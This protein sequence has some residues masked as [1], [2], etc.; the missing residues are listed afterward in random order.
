MGL[1]TALRSRSLVTW[2]L[3]CVAMVAVV[4][5]VLVVAPWLLT[6]YPHHGLTADQVLKAK[7]DVR[8]TLT[9]ALAGIAVAGGLAVTYRSYRLSKSEQ[10]TET[11]TRAIE[12]LGHTDAPVRLGALY[13]LER[14]GQDNPDRRRTVVDV[15]CA[16]LRMP[17]PASADPNNESADATA[18]LRSGERQRPEQELQVRKTA[19]RL[20][21]AHVQRP[22]NTRPEDAAQMRP[23]TQI[24]F[25]PNI[26]LDLVGATLIEFKLHDA[27][28]EVDFRQATFIGTASFAGATFARGALFDGATFK[29]DASFTGAT[30]KR[31]A[32]IS[33]VTF[34]GAAWFHGV[35]FTDGVA[36]D[37]A[38]FNG[39]AQFDGATFGG[40]ASFL[41]TKFVETIR[42]GYLA[43]FDSDSGV[44]GPVWFAGA[45]FG[46][47]ALF[48][49]TTLTGEEGWDTV[50]VLNPNVAYTRIWPT[51]WTLRVDPNDPTGGRLIRD[52]TR[53]VEPD[54][55]MATD[56]MGGAEPN[57]V[58]G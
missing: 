25:W 46:A 18:E 19:Q 14:L 1:R 16:Y 8:T 24:A 56:Q 38:I 7:S 13:S 9:Q 3:G 4:A 27:I 40:G 43:E 21:A 6:R 42:P 29:H 22:P 52:A 30:F 49:K 33:G 28:A 55:A 11:Y 51:G 44:V 12:Q 37:G 5:L 34:T 20:L 15:L 2:I 35:T 31:V 50:R 23:S 36:F 54:S 57:E 58:S 26:S 39:Y 32:L 45:T 48:I 53:P 17:P 47:E 41:S 10:V